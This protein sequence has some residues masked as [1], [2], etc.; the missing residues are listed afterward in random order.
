MTCL[1]DFRTWEG[2]G[3]GRRGEGRMEKVARVGEEDGTSPA[4][5]LCREGPAVSTKEKEGLG[6]MGRRQ[7][8]GRGS[9]E[10][11]VGILSRTVGWVAC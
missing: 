6:E 8:A 1:K 2:R 9:C 5:G 10:P 7:T 3:R 11:Q 4:S